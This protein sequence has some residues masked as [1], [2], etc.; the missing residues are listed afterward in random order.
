MESRPR[1]SVDEV[2]V[3]TLNSLRLVALEIVDLVAVAID[4]HGTGGP[5]DG[6]TAVAAVVLHSLAALALPR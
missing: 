4:E 6:R 3:P 1:R 5:H 2:V